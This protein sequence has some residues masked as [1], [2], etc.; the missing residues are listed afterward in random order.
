MNKE[1]VF[2][3]KKYLFRESSEPEYS[4][5]FANTSAIL[6]DYYI[7]VEDF[8]ENTFQIHWKHPAT[9]KEIQAEIENGTIISAYTII[10]K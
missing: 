8:E 6:K 9:E 1:L 3:G 5:N 10:S 2:C 4:D 7:C